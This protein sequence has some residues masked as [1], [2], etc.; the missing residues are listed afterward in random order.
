GADDLYLAVF[1]GW[2]L[3]SEAGTH[4]L[5]AVVDDAYDLSIDGRVVA[6]GFGG[7]QVPGTLYLTAGWHRFT[8]R[9]AEYS[10]GDSYVAQWKT[11]SNGNWTTIPAA[12]FGFVPQTRS[13][14]TA[15][16]SAYE[17][18]ETTG[19]WGSSDGPW[20]AGTS[21]SD[22][23]LQST[24]QYCYR[25]RARD[26]QGNTGTWSDVAC[27][28]TPFFCVPPANVTAVVRT[29]PPRTGD[30]GLVYFT[31]T[32]VGGAVGPWDLQQ[33]FPV[34]Q[35]LASVTG[36]SHTLTGLQGGRQACYRIG[37]AGDASW[38]DP[39]CVVTPDRLDPSSPSFNATAVNASN[40]MDLDWGPAGTETPF[41]SPVVG[42][43]RD[44]QCGCLWTVSD[45]FNWW[46]TQLE[47][48]GITVQAVEDWQVDTLPE[49]QHFDVLVNP[50]GECMP[51]TNND[52]AML[53]N[54]RRFVHGGGLWF[55]AGGSTMHYSDGAGTGSPD[56]GYGGADVVCVDHIEGSQDGA[57]SQTAEGAALLG[58]GLPASYAGPSQARGSRGMSNPG[59]SECGDHPRYVPLYSKGEPTGSSGGPALHCYGG[60]CVVRTDGVAD[61][62]LTDIYVRIMR[63]F[64]STSLYHSLGGETFAPVAG[65]DDTF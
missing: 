48:R 9:F 8:L 44:P 55:E 36:T 61:T 12:A 22:G 25:I 20:Q 37:C 47:A 50:Y 18:E 40:R 58:A 38:S 27:A 26:A 41:V 28:T 56:L 51:G 29:F 33:A 7:A 52:N 11:P 34:E 30:E 14:V 6:T 32:A 24:T 64:V 65:G 63:R 46:K 15:G 3:A 13:V 45:C 21:F 16:T 35:S 19:N 60:G 31:W 43:V 5:Q 49:M 53:D 1:D 2:L 62:T 42:L 54:V 4:Q 57:R 39:V 10:G 17:I 23:G 59:Y